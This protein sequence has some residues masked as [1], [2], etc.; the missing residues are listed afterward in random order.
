MMHPE[1]MLGRAYSVNP[2]VPGVNTG[3]DSMVIWSATAL[4]M[5]QVWLYALRL[6]RVN[7]RDRSPAKAC[8][9]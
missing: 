5:S 8:S 4:Q 1:T 3:L 6:W 9:R 7:G 2:V